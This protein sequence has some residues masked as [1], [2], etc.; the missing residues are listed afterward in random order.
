MY[1]QSLHAS[2]RRGMLWVL[3]QLHVAMTVHF[4]EAFGL[5]YTLFF[6]Q[7]W[8]S[9]WCDLAC[10]HNWIRLTSCHG[11]S[12][13]SLQC[14]YALWQPVRAV[15]QPCEFSHVFNNY[16]RHRSL[17]CVC[18]SSLLFVSLP[19]NLQRKY[20]LQCNGS[21]LSSFCGASCYRAVGIFC[22]ACLHLLH[23]VLSMRK[24][25]S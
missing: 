24:Y 6:T 15:R 18:T 4:E 10:C 5:L 7:A 2:R 22:S 19:F 9:L 11:S 8:S 13:S 21:T 25:H 14:R 20:R 12:V 1:L 17:M 3:H 16:S 23:H